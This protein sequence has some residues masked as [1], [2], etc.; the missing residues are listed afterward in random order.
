[1]DV[2]AGC[3]HPLLL[4]ILFFEIG[5]LT[6]PGACLYGPRHL[7]GLAG[8]QAPET[9]PS[10]AA[11]PETIGYAASLGSYRGDAGVMEF[12]TSWEKT[13]DQSSYN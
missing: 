1:M 4:S 9:C 5:P 13:V 11:Q 12:V 2:Y 6:E 7:S 3:C 8:H 10:P